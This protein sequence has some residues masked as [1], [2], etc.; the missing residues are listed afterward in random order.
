MMKNY[1]R[2]SLDD[3]LKESE[4]FE[5]AFEGLM[6][7]ADGPVAAELVSDISNWLD[8]SLNRGATFLLTRWSAERCVPCWTVGGR[9]YASAACTSRESRR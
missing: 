7:S 1:S 8:L 6:K 5:V 2:K 4:R 3:L 9:G